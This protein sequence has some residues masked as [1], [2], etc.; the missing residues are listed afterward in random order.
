M[1]SAGLMSVCLIFLCFLAVSG[2]AQKVPETKGDWTLVWNDEFN[3]KGEPDPVKWYYDVGGHGWGNGEIQNY[4]MDRENSVVD[5][6]RLHIK[7]VRESK[8]RWTSARLVTRKRADWL[9]GRFEIRAKLP[10]GTGTWPAIWML[11]VTDTYGNWPYSGEIDIMEHVGFDPGEVHTTAH[12]M[13][14]NHKIGTQKTHHEQVPGVTKKFHVYACEWEPEEIR[15][16]IDDKLFYTFA[17][18]GTGYEAWPFDI[19]FYLIMNVAIGGGWG[20]QEGI[21]PEL[22]EAVMEIDYVRVYQ[23]QAVK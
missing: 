12:T 16:F 2:C 19:P 3:Y 17:N 20:G 23:K 10:E 5:R 7:A 22:D 18:E 13:K 11:P 4:T 21:D 8:R 9:Y 6:G 14:Y 15:F 1:K